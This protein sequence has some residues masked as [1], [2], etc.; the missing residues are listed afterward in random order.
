M[1]WKLY[2]EKLEDIISRIDMPE[3]TRIL[4]NALIDMSKKECLIEE[5]TE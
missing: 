4:V 5:E 2:A 3:P 1:D